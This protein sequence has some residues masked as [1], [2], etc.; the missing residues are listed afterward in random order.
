PR[1]GGSR[2]ARTLISTLFNKGPYGLLAEAEKQGYKRMEFYAGKCH[3]CTSIRQF[4][5]DNDLEKSIVGPAECY[6][7]KPST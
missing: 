5:R 7:D 1:L 6:S 3:L 2:T 4:L